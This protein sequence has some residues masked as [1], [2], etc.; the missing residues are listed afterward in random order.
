VLTFAALFKDSTGNVI[1]RF[2]GGK[3]LHG[4]EIGNSASWK[5]Y[6]E[7]QLEMIGESVRQIARF[8]E[9]NGALN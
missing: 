9:T 3:S 6:E 1:G 2:T 8:V 7:M 4:G 5:S